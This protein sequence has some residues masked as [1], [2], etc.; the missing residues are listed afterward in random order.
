MTM[1]PTTRRFSAVRRSLARAG[2][3][4]ICRWG[5]RYFCICFLLSASSIFLLR[6]SVSCVMRPSRRFYVFLFSMQLVL[7]FASSLFSRALPT[8]PLPSF[9][10]FLFLILKFMIHC[11]NEIPT[12]IRYCYEYYVSMRHLNISGL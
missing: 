4:Q 2:P 9:Y 11:M 5:R 1:A 10:S 7:C 3:G 12:Q 8:T 6:S